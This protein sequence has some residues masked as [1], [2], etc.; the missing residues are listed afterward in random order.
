[1]ASVKK[2]GVFIIKTLLGI[3]M[4]YRDIMNGILMT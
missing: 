1:M 3:I 4:T 2:D